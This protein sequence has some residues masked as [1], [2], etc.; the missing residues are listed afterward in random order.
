MAKA[1]TPK[2]GTFIKKDIFTS[3]SFQINIFLLIMEFTFILIKLLYIMYS[4]KR[5][6]YSKFPQYIGRI[7]FRIMHMKLEFYVIGT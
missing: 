1:C 3:L 5:I 7:L 6:K 2:K 4:Y